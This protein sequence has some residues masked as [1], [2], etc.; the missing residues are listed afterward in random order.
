MY[1][2]FALFLLLFPIAFGQNSQLGFV[3]GGGGMA[4]IFETSAY[5]FIAGAE[6]CVWCGGRLGL[7]MEYDHWT[8]TSSGTGDPV[9]L[10]LVSAGARVQGKGSRFRPFLD[11]G[12]TGG[13]ERTARGF[14]SGPRDTRGVAG[15]VLGV[16]VAISITERWYVRPMGRLIGLSSAEFGGFAGAAIGYRF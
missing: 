5:H 7:F 1:R 14:V 6:G 15:G 10:D 13:G 9:G 11:I 12:F 8:K 3:A 2:L 4:R 16:G